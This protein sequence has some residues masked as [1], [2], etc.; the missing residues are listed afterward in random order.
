MTHFIQRYGNPRYVDPDF[1]QFAEY[2]RSHYAVQWLQPIFNVLQLKL[3][4]KLCQ[5][6]HFASRVSRKV[7]ICILLGQYLTDDVY[8]NAITFISNSC[9]MS[10]TYKVIKPSLDILLFQVIFPTLC[11]NNEEIIEF[12]DDPTEFIQKVS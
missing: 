7:I 12:R 2:F 4:G 11:L 5:A 3:T 8:R 6:S 10:P 1:V 9:E